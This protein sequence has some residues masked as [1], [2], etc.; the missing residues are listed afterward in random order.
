MLTLE[1]MELLCREPTL[2]TTEAV[3]ESGGS[4][5]A[6]GGD[7]RASAAEPRG[8]QDGHQTSRTRWSSVSVR[9]SPAG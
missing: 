9:T 8:G 2:T 6:L 4:P 5:V 1:L 3:T 7:R